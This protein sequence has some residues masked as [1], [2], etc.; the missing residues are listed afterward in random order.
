MPTGDGIAHGVRI[1][2]RRP[3][4]GRLRRAGQRRGVGVAPFVARPTII[5]TARA[6]GGADVE[7]F[8]GHIAHIRQVQVA[9]GRVE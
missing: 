6:R 3:N 4:G 1:L 5:F 9:G 2:G 7:L 8:P